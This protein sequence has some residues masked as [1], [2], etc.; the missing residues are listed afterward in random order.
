MR[1]FR[2]RRAPEAL[3]AR[4]RQARVTLDTERPGSR[5]T[6]RAALGIVTRSGGASRIAE[7]SD[8]GAHAGSD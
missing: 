5:F 3:R 1:R 4:Y 6:S 2:R 8:T 7:G